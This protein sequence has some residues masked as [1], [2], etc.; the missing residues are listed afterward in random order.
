MD[1]IKDKFYGLTVACSIGDAMGSAADMKQ[2]DGLDS[3]VE[4]PEEAEGYWN[5]ACTLMLCQMESL[6][7]GEPFLNVLDEACKTGQFTSTGDVTNLCARTMKMRLIKEEPEECRHHSDCLLPIGAIAMYYVKDYERGHVEAYHSALAQGCQLCMDACKFYH[8]VLDLAL[9]GGSK[10]HILSPGSY[11][12]LNLHTDVRSLLPLDPDTKIY[13]LD[14]NGDDN[15]IACLKMVL[16]VFH[17]T[18]NISDGLKMIVNYSRAPVRTGSLLGQLTG[19]YYGLINVKEEWLDCLKSKEVLTN[20]TRALL[21][22]MN[23][24]NLKSK[25]K[26]KTKANSKH[27]VD[28][29]NTQ[30]GISGVGDE[31]EMSPPPS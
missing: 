28:G 20:L 23:L 30:H 15:V 16:Y 4:H 14:L 29:R 5:E 8:A 27:H 25:I 2:Q 12:N 7:T 11:V 13:D 22:K 1:L 10:K 18:D 9:H 17:F 19:S 21:P 6:R 31:P 24:P 3:D 26:N